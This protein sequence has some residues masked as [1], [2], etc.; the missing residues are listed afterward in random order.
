MTIDNRSKCPVCFD[1]YLVVE[2]N[3]HSERCLSCGR[4]YYPFP[5]DI[6][7]DNEADIEPVSGYD[8]DDNDSPILLCEKPKESK[9]DSYLR[10]HFGSGVTIESTLEIPESE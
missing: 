5:T 1:S 2:D 3:G 7:L 10:R 6:D 9:P 8:S 4:V